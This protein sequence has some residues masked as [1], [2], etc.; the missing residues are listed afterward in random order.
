[1][2]G[3][4]IR[5]GAPFALSGVPVLDVD[6]GRAAAFAARDAGERIVAMFAADGFAPDAVRVFVAT[7]DDASASLRILAF[8]VPR[9]VGAYPA[10][11]PQWTEAHMF[12]REIA[13]QFGVRPTGHPWLKPVRG[14][15]PLAGP[16]L[17]PP[18]EGANTRLDAYPFLAAGGDEMHEVGVGPVHAGIIE[19]GHFRFLCHGETVFHL[20]ISL[21]Y[22]H[23]GVER[24]VIGGPDKRSLV[25]MESAAGDTVIGHGYAHCRVM[26]GL[27]ASTSTA[28]GAALRCVALELERCANHVGDLG[29]L[30]ND[31]GYLP[32]AAWFGRLRGEFLNLL[33]DLSGNRYGRGMLRPGGVRFD[34]DA[35]MARDFETRLV[36]ARADFHNIAE[37]LF[38]KPSVNARFDGTGKVVREEAE[39]L[40]L[41]GPAAR[42]SGCAR[43]VRQDFAHGAYRFVHVP[44]ALAET[45]D[46]AA[47][48]IVRRIETERAIEFLIEQVGNLPSG[49]LFAPPAPPAASTGCLAMVEG[50][51]GEIAHAALTD[52]DGRLARYKVVDPSFHNWTGLAMALRGQE[53]SDFP[54]VNKSFNLSYAGNDL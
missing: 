7:A 23:R 48:A 29:A 3:L 43:D 46:V 13:E 24:R 36:R 49:A 33:M 2:T 15:P 39:S 45:G 42:A 20:E 51:R 17:F 35:D 19:P 41:V 11:T 14:S 26:E 27:S 1:M 32:G 37:L 16:D 5:S 40:G 4:A 47:R 54:L 38:T 12:E 31:V 34:V 9:A 53:I 21:G 50:W 25:T 28:R 6:A 30:A 22:Q 44:V 8:D 18:P 10:F 52:A